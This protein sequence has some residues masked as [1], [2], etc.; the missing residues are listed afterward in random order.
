VSGETFLHFAALWIQ[1][2]VMPF[3]ICLTKGDPPVREC[4][5]IP[6]LIVTYPD[7]GPDP[8]FSRVG[9]AIRLVL[10]LSNEPWAVGRLAESGLNAE[11]VRDA[12]IL[13]TIDSLSQKLSSAAHSTIAQAADSAAKGLSL[14]RGGVLTIAA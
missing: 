8:F 4:W 12:R 7:P 2:D 6:V 13:A 3:T 9:K 5:D 1:E 11:T 10:G 14:P